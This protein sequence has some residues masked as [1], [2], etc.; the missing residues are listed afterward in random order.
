M[1]SYILN[2]EIG[3]HQLVFSL[4]VEEFLKIIEMDS[5]RILK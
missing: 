3:L 1:G 2:L 5:I 4:H